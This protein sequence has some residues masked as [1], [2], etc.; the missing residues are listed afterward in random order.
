MPKQAAITLGT[1]A[2]LGFKPTWVA[3]S[4]LSDAPLMHRVTKGLWEGVLYASI[5]E[6]PNSKHPLVVKYRKAY[7]DYGKTYDE[8]ETWSLFFMA[9]FT[10]AEPFV[11]GLRRAGPDLDREKLVTAMESL[12]SWSG[13]IS[14]DITFGPDIRQGQKSIF[15]ARCEGGQG[16]RVTPW[17]TAKD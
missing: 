15:V 13:G 7:E 6:L 3:S 14:N 9:G 12:K 1:A 17:I 4:A 2:K 5:M 11:E 10:F 8:K 16:V